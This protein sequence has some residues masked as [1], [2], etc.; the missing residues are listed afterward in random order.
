MK[1]GQRL[2]RC[3]E[4]GETTAIHWVERNRAGRIQCCAC[5][6]MAIDPVSSEAREEVRIGNLNVLEDEPPSVVK[7]GNRVHKEHSGRRR[8]T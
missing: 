7:S 6:S 8:I 2:Y 5:G 1:A 4:C 3:S